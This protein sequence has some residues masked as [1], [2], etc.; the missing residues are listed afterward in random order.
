MKLRRIYN[1]F[2]LTLALVLCNSTTQAK[3]I[4]MTGSCMNEE[5][6]KVIR[7]IVVFKDNEVRALYSGYGNAMIDKNLYTSKKD[8]RI[9][10]NNGGRLGTATNKGDGIIT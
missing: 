3:E 10:L 2:G 7:E 4:L 8:L 6:E 1:L 9:F 5:G